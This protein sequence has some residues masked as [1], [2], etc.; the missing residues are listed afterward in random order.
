MNVEERTKDHMDLSQTQVKIFEITEI[1]FKKKMVQSEQS[2]LSDSGVQFHTWNQEPH[3]NSL[4]PN[5][6]N[7]EAKQSQ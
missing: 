2:R 6:R 4:V 1:K 3:Q 7:P 5:L